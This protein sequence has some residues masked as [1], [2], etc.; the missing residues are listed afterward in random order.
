MVARPKDLNPNRAA[1]QA[2]MIATI[3]GFLL[4]IT[5]ISFIARDANA[6]ESST[7]TADEIALSRAATG[8]LTLPSALES[9][10]PNAFGGIRAV[11]NSTLIVSIVERESLSDE[12]IGI[13]EFVNS[14]ASDS[15]DLV[16]ISMTI[17][18]DSSTTSFVQRREVLDRLA[19]R[20]RDSGNLSDIGISSVG[21]DARGIS[22]GMQTANAKVEEQIRGDFPE[23]EFNFTHIP[24]PDL[25][26]GR[27]ADVSPW[28][29]GDSLAINLFGSPHMRCTSGPGAH[30]ATGDRYLLTA[31]HCGNFFYYN[32]N[33]GSPS[34]SNPVG[35]MSTSIFTNWYPDIGRIAT[36]SSMYFW[37][38]P[39]SGTRRTTLAPVDPV[40]GYSVCGQGMVTAAWGATNCGTVSQI[41]QDLEV[42]DASTGSTT[43]VSGQFLWDGS[44]SMSG[45]SGGY[46]SL[47]TIYG[48]GAVGTITAS[49]STASPPY[50]I[51]TPI[52]FHTFIWG[53]TLNTP[54]TP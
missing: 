9:R 44:A 38:G 53:L 43:W 17:D 14:V 22:I 13:K 18:F 6:S 34:F 12:A 46:I 33:F 11:D 4:L 10:F 39:G 30:S 3:V 21:M 45:D 52:A 41:N 48:Y 36:N 8:I 47:S 16:G 15:L 1:R 25:T 24:R 5:A 54:S 20:I 50:S 37:E 35:P 32:T 2:V 27:F 40:V 28:N 23:I 19:S 31:G 42:Y 29:G 7:S 49:K 26:T 51:G